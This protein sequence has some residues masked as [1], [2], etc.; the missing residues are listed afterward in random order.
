[1]VTVSKGS[2]ISWNRM[3]QCYTLSYGSK[4]YGMRRRVAV[5]GVLLYK[6]VWYYMVRSVQE[7]KDTLTET[8]QNGIRSYIQ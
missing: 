3:L 5:L 1:M 6:M 7:G 2:E 4:T 8:L